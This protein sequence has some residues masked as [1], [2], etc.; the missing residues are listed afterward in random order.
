MNPGGGR[1]GG[2]E[3]FLF[4]VYLMSFLN[5]MSLAFIYPVMPAYATALGATIAQVGVV[6]ALLPYVSAGAQPFAGFFSDRINR[7][8]SLIVGA[9]LNILCFLLYLFTPA[10]GSLM[11]VRI[12]HG[13]S[14][15]VFFPAA[16]SLVVDIA[17]Q[18][19]RGQALGL[20]TTATQL[21]NMTGP[22]V[23][24]FVLKGFGFKATFLASAFIMTLALV[25]VLFL[26]RFVRTE[27][28]PTPA[29]RI[30]LKWFRDRRAII[31][32]L[33][34]MFV[35]VGIA[36][37]ISFLPLYGEEIGIDISRVGLLIACVYFGSVLTRVIAGRTSDRVGRVPVILVGL[38]LCTIGIFLVS[39]FT[40]EFL[41]YGACFIFGVGMG[42]V[43]PATI[44]LIADVAPPWIRG[45]ALGLMGSFFYGGQAIGATVLGMVAASAG[46]SKMY[47]VTAGTLGCI[48]LVIL[49]LAPRKS[50][51]R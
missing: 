25:I 8:I 7:R 31:A 28:G 13:F 44:A 39:I 27:A 34:T 42:A 41:L 29:F 36:S 19:K 6:V 11:I 20:F 15:A 3:I 49:V 9:A 17:S 38:S 46:F 40:R 16:S 14:C 47:L 48:I 4:P 21:G 43:L 30:T 5:N 10:L 1:Q 2:Q 18:E 12:L 22:A 37:V 26:L 33:A 35:M 45:F 23:G 24:G 32:N 50:K 51:T